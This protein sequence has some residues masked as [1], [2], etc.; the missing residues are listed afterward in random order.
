M[1]SSHRG[2]ATGILDVGR[3]RAP[4][5]RWQL[6]YRLLRSFLPD[7]DECGGIVMAS[8]RAESVT[9]STPELSTSTSMVVEV[10]RPELRGQLA[11]CFRVGGSRQVFRLMPVRDPAQPR[12]WAM[13]VVPCLESGAIMM[14]DAIWA[15]HRGSDWTTM[16]GLLADIA[17]DLSAWLAADTQKQ[18]RL[19]VEPPAADLP[20]DLPLPLT[21][22]DGSALIQSALSAD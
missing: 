21:A 11:L 17:A 14:Q 5:L 16:A 10:L 20:L 3:V 12:F 19:L 1:V 4:S 13:A 8:I 6:R 22:L 18:L 2:P 15:G 9:P 7:G